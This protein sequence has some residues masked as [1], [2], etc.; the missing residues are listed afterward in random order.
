[1]ERVLITGGL[2]F[3]GKSIVNSLMNSGYTITLLDSLEPSR[4]GNNRNFTIFEEWLGKVNV[5]IGSVTNKT[6]FFNLLNN[7]DIVIHLA[8]QVSVPAS[9]KYSEYYC[10]HNVIGTANLRDY[11][12]DHNN[13]KKLFSL[14]LGLFMA[15]DCIGAQIIVQ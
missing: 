8:S 6:L 9:E 13:V 5:V 11:I 1:M 15:R 7:T 3:I 2:G 4:H 12:K 10:N 14:L